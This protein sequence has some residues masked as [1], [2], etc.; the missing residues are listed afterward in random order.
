MNSKTII[1][2]ILGGICSFL[3][4][5][6]LYGMLLKDLFAGMAGSATGVMRTDEEMVWWALILGNLIIGFLVAYIFSQWAGISTFMGGLRGGAAMGLFFTAGFDFI[7]YGTTNVSQLSGT[8]LD[9]AVGVVMWGLAS[10][11]TG[12]WLGRS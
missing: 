10:G 1:A 9:M 3:L 8:L 6:V 5:F 7:F 4:G 2:G 12:W 11:V